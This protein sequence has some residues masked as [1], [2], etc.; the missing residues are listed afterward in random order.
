MQC[1][2]KPRVS[3]PLPNSCGHPMV[4]PLVKADC[5]P[6][7]KPGLYRGGCWRPEDSERL[8]TLRGGRE[9]WGGGG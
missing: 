8:L 1:A 7:D 6:M 4:R 3:T 9:D 2:Q 5:D